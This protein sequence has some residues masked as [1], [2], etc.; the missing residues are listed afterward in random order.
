MADVDQQLRI[1]LD[2]ASRARAIL[3]DSLVKQSFDDLERELIEAMI[4]TSA[5][6]AFRREKIHMMLVF[7]RKWRNTFAS[8]IE[9]G[10]LAELQL[11]EKRKFKLWSR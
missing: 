10:K 2:R 11:E 3:E 1:E 9:T 7:G 8:M 6:D 5:E 4:S